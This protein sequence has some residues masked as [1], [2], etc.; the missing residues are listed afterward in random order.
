MTRLGLPL[1]VASIVFMEA[2]A[3]NSQA[4]RTTTQSAIANRQSAIRQPEP[5][6]EHVLRRINPHDFDYGVWLE[7]RRAVLLQASLQNP[8]FWYSACVTIAMALFLLAYAK[9]YSD[10][11]K[12]TWMSAG[13]L[14]DFHNETQ[15]ARDEMN[16][17]IEKH[18]R[19]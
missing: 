18:N 10:F 8:Y 12:Y 19:H 6:Y 1:L 15:L 9:S 3:Q 14:A 16:R 4:I 2:F 7:E 17:A 11:H 13:W 5:W